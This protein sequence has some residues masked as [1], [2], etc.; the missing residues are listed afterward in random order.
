MLKRE[1][2]MNSFELLYNIPL[3]NI[4]SHTL[5]TCSPTDK[6]LSYFGLTLLNSIILYILVHV[7]LCKYDRV[8]LTTFNSGIASCQAQKSSISIS[9]TI[10]VAGYFCL[11]P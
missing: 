3:Y 4:P 11:P 1:D 9:L 5:P 10:D 8:S 6:I 2:V 7:S